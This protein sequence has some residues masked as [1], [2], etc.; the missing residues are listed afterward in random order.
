[1]DGPP[2]SIDGHM[3]RPC[4]GVAPRTR[5]ASHAFHVHNSRSVSAH[6]DAGE[7]SPASLSGSGSSPCSPCLLQAA[8]QYEQ[9]MLQY[10]AMQTENQKRM[11]EA[12]QRHAQAQER[13]A[14]EAEQALVEA[15]AAHA[16]LCAQLA[17]DSQQAEA[18]RQTELERL[19]LQVNCWQGGRTALVAWQA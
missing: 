11:V 14:R 5:A 1:M 2:S 18:A 17:A 10:Q 4:G 8:A 19:Q 12:R 15:R 16:A 7:A 13:Q 3:R 6:Q 9:A